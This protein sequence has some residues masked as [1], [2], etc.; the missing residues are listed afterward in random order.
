MEQYLQ[1]LDYIL[2]KG[3][4]KKDRTG[5]GTLSVFGYD[6]R[7]DLSRGLPIITTKKI[8]FKSILHELLWFI[9]GDTNTRYLTEHGVTIWNEWADEAGNLGPIYGK[10]WR[11]WKGY[12]GKPIDQLANLI[13]DINVNPHSRRLIISAWN[14]G[15]LHQMN[16]MPC[17]AFMQFYVQG[18][19]L[20]CKL[21]QRSADAFLG[22][23][24]NITSYA[25]LVHM[26]AMQTNL[27]LGELIWSGG[28]C[29]I[30]QNHLDVVKIQLKR[31]PFSL[32]EIQIK[33]KSSIDQYVYQDFNL[34]GYQSH[35]K[36][37]AKI[38]I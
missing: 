12:D 6:M 2:T 34:I 11:K 30:Y 8:H 27:L 10:Q 29:H 24:F 5:V 28:D 20:S 25:L 37:S 21:T 1:F 14:V 23:P 22:V 15:D 16:L 31:T 18:N 13:N 7:F 19:Q 4:P 35:D 26:I 17:H 36:L 3:K 32:P 38:A 33:N 9:D